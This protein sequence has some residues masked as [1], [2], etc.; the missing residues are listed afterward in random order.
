MLM[1]LPD[2]GLEKV[3]AELIERAEQYLYGRG[4]EEI[5]AIGVGEVCPFYLGLYGGSD[6]PGVLVSDTAREALFRAQGYEEVDRVRV[7]QR[8][9]VG[10]RPKVDRA[11][12][13][14]GRNTTVDLISDSPPRSWW[15]ACTHA[16]FDQVR[17]ELR[18]RDGGPAIA[19]ATFWDMESLDRGS[20]A[21]TIG[22]AHIDVAAEHEPEGPA[23]YL[24]GES[25]R[26][27]Q[28]LGFTSVEGQA[29]HE[30]ENAKQVFEALGFTQIDSGSVLRK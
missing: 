9:L 6:L 27:F 18:P 8:Q 17:V 11:Q 25:L 22:L 29:M 14:I 16:C 30:D 23:R 3:A 4:A 26:K 21:H 28:P 2:D 10:F 24:L 7:F 15:E 20:D 19:G 13:Q 1:L 5:F 12:L